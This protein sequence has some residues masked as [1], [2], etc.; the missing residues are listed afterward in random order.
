MENAIAHANEMYVPEKKNKNKNL[1]VPLTDDQK[2]VTETIIDKL[3]REFK[4]CHLIHGKYMRKA[5]YVKSKLLDEERKEV[6]VKDLLSKEEIDE[7][8][9]DVLEDFKS[10]FPPPK[11]VKR[12]AS[13]K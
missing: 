13:K 8:L 10:C 2:T 12:K 6:E 1:S 9:G 5:E 3:T 4:S 11:G 7:L